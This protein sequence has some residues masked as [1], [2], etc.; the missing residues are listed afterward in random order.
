MD[1]AAQGVCSDYQ[2][3]IRLSS[4]ILLL[5]ITN[6][7]GRLTARA[8][9]LDNGPIVPLLA[10]VSTTSSQTEGG[11]APRSPDTNGGSMPSLPITSSHLQTED[12]ATMLDKAD[13]E[14][15]LRRGEPLRNSDGNGSSIPLAT[16]RLSPDWG[17]QAADRG[18]SRSPSVRSNGE[19]GTVNP[20]T[21][22]PSGP[23]ANGPL[24]A[25]PSV[26][27]QSKTTGGAPFQR[28]RAG[29][30]SSS[31]APSLPPP[32]IPLPSV[33]SREPQGQQQEQKPAGL[34]VSYTTENV[35][36]S[37]GLTPKEDVYEFPLPP[38]TPSVPLYN[39]STAALAESPVTVQLDPMRNLT[40]DRSDSSG[41][42]VKQDD[43]LSPPRFGPSAWA[44][45]KDDAASI[46][47]KGSSAR[48]RRLIRKQQP[49]MD[50][51]KS[52]WPEAGDPKG[53]EF[54]NKR[55]D[56][57]GRVVWSARDEF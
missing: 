6:K 38:S 22:P 29:S 56:G 5:G 17:T 50:L 19:M 49:A 28:L 41:S 3:S 16:R 46:S 27:D 24:A 10:A 14:W 45:D 18:A 30:S 52:V 12:L 53:E 44:E 2:V 47:S 37:G 8:E 40:I 43:H 23:P 33:P 26:A 20:S 9:T 39:G 31:P 7:R 42:A 15:R 21:T 11:E 48:M 54:G 51:S 35:S 1:P 36:A 25:A 4:L 34:L 55:A 13:L 32:T 57:S